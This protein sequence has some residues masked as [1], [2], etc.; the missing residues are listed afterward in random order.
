MALV[1]NVG[2]LKIFK[3]TTLIRFKNH[4]CLKSIL[5]TLLKFGFGVRNDEKRNSL[6]VRLFATHAMLKNQP[7]NNAGFLFMVGL[8]I[9]V[10]AGVKFAE[11]TNRRIKKHSVKSGGVS[12][13]RA[14]QKSLPC[15]SSPTPPPGQ[16]RML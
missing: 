10:D 8:D 6:S 4:R 11:R 12:H 1:R 14:Y 5:E 15:Q 16:K 7:L 3:L 13:S 2:Q 9:G